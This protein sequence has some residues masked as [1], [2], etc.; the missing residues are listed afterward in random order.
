MRGKERS[1]QPLA[2][3]ALDGYTRYAAEV[4]LP[5]LAELNGELAGVKTS[6][7]D[8][9]YVHQSRVA[10]RRIRAALPFFKGCFEQKTYKFW[11]RQVRNITR[12]LGPARDLD[13][14]IAFLNQFIETHTADD[15]SIP[16][17]TMEIEQVVNTE[18]SSKARGLV[19]QPLLKDIAQEPDNL[20]DKIQD[21]LHERKQ[22]SIQH[23][24]SAPGMQALSLLK[25]PQTYNRPGL[26]CLLLRLKQHREAIEPDVADAAV[27]FELSKT[28]P[29]MHH[30]LL[31]HLTEHQE[32][33]YPDTIYT[34]AIASIRYLIQNLCWY[35]PAVFDPRK[36]SMHHE[37]RIAAKHLRYTLEA[38]NGLYNGGLSSEMK[39]VKKLQTLLGDLHDCDVWIELLPQF[40]DTEREKARSYFGNTTFFSLISPGVLF[41][42]DNRMKERGRLYL[43]LVE[44]WEKLVGDEFFTIL[45]E[46]VQKSSI[47]HQNALNEAKQDKTQA[48]IEQNSD[49]PIKEEEDL[50]TDVEQLPTASI[51]HNAMVI[52]LI[53]D[54][55]ANLPALIA[56]LADAKKRGATMIFNAGDLTGYGPYPEE[57]VKILRSSEVISITGNYDRSLLTQWWLEE[58]KEPSALDW[59]ADPEDTFMLRLKREISKWTYEALSQDSRDY[60][61]HLPDHL[62]ETLYGQRVLLVHGSPSSMTEYITAET[63]KARL[64]EIALSSNADI[65]VSGHAHMPCDREVDQVRFINTGSVGRS[66]D[67][68]PRACYTLLSCGDDNSITV[69]H[70]RIS[71]DID[72]TINKMEKYGLP[73]RYIR[74]I[75]EGRSPDLLVDNNEQYDTYVSRI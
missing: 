5:L 43:E 52:A 7:N 71:Y 37:M 60:L 47:S 53:G 27:L 35:A 8:I 30:Y 44:Y 23:R 51:Q 29:M 31:T 67:G 61:A 1:I 2:D 33:P 4:L 58:E 69:E 72:E 11:I 57:V 20:P 34:D 70:I 19:P 55:H 56:V 46:K 38:C 49:I 22:T 42:L 26:E 9:E 54:V 50:K 18:T 17:F 6:S 64:S 21:W 45:T 62:R 66:E 25:H 75:R 12:T 16:L 10:S 28:L 14:Q 15:T 48:N 63:P 36:T 59:D 40:L 74:A 68:D 13:V 65:I 32:T 3:D 73:E 24:D 41:L 39:T